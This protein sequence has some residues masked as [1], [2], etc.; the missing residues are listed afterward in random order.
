M[1][2]TSVWFRTLAM[3]GGALLSG[4]AC[5]E[6]NPSRLATPGDAAPS[7][8]K[9]EYGLHAFKYTTSSTGVRREEV[10]FAPS[11]TSSTRAGTL[12]GSPPARGT[13][14]DY[15]SPPVSSLTPADLAYGAY[16]SCNQ[17]VNAD[18]QVWQNGNWFLIHEGARLGGSE[19]IASSCDEVLQHQQDFLC[20]AERLAEIADAVRP[21]AWLNHPLRLPPAFRA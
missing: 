9:S 3:V 16:L 7:V 14:A 13:N 17:F 18:R 1:T 20:V 6:E 15:D 12:G 2:R 5:T 11:A 19:L 8:G 4:A 21:V 10:T